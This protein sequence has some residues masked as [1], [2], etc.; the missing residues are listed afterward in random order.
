MLCYAGR[1]HT[2]EYSD[3]LMAVPGESRHEVCLDEMCIFSLVVVARKQRRGN[4]LCD[5]GIPILRSP[6]CRNSMLLILQ[7]CFSPCNH[8]HDMTGL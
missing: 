5:V 1:R 6:S 7:L 8:P 4:S 3:I 2:T